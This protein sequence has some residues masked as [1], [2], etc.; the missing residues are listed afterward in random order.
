MPTKKARKP[1]KKKSSAA[2]KSKAEIQETLL[3]PAKKSRKAA[4]SKSSAATKSKVKVQKSQSVPTK[5]ARK[6]AKKETPATAKSKAEVL[7][8]TRSVSAKNTRK[9]AKSKSSTATKSKA[10]VQETVSMPT[11]KSTKKASTASKTK[12][13]TRAIPEAN[14]KKMGDRSMQLFAE[15]EDLTALEPADCEDKPRK[16]RKRSKKKATAIDT[17]TP[18]AIPTGEKLQREVEIL[19]ARIQDLESQLQRGGL[20][21]SKK[22]IYETEKLGYAYKGDVLEPLK[23]S[24]L[25]EDFEG[26]NAIRAPLTSTGQTIGSMYIEA[27][28]EKIWNPEEENLANAIAEQASLQIQSLRLLA[29]AEQAR[30]EAEEATRSF[31]HES[32]ESYLDAIHQDERIGYA[33]D[34]ASVSPYLDAPE[35]EDDYQEQVKVMDEQVGTLALKQDPASP[36]SDDDKKMVSSVAN[37]IAQQV[38]NIRLLADAS[39]ARAEAEEATR[40]LT[41]E[42]WGSFA[43]RRE[44]DTLGFIYDTVKISPVEDKTLPEKIAL[45][46]PLEIRG[47]AIGQLAVAGEESQSPDALKLAAAIAAQTSLHL[48]TLRLAE[49]LQQRAEELQEM[50]RLKSGFLANMSHELRTPLNSILGFADVVL[51]ELDGPLTPEMSNDLQLIQ[52]NGQHLL[53]LIND[54][55]DMAKIESG[56]MNLSPETFKVHDMLE[57]VNSITSTL[58]SE[59]NIALFIEKDSDKDVEIFADNTRLRQVMINLVNNSIK[60]T[61]AR[62]KIAIRAVK[63]DNDTVLVTVKDTGLG[64]PSEKLEVIFQEFTQVDTS[65]TRKTGGT[66]L[67]LPISRRLIEMHGG[68]LWAESTGI[69]GEGSTLFAELPLEAHIPDAIEITKGTIEK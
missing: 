23:L 57:E 11:K 31:M 33:Y 27:N 49:E 46:V 32:W 66:G 48:E 64:I 21:T 53:H 39:R 8:E 42:S 9:A 37:Q 41:Q 34:Q 54:V 12:V 10:K 1:T 24:N 62:G 63:Q 22:E 3:S 30:A 18:L 60:F 14:W 52:R 17:T 28:P 19:R 47:K 67:G 29:S 61:E 69:S 43:E 45:T 13:K 15:I 55:L 44:G 2:T 50:D 20:P 65:S 40:R 38:E 7:Q 59:K 4:K 6:P 36:L 35:E 58:A 25:E 56:R 68:R 51:L 26:I 16:H 5:K